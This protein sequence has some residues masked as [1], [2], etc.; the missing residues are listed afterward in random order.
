MYSLATHKK[1]FRIFLFTNKLLIAEDKS[2]RGEDTVKSDISDESGYSSLKQEEH[3]K[4]SDKNTQGK[5]LKPFISFNIN[6]EL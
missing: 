5:A 3:F 4:Y 2:E 1:T 6:I